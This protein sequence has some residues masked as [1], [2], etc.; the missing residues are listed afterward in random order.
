MCLLKVSALSALPSHVCCSAAGGRLRI[1][2]IGCQL[3]CDS[4]DRWRWWLVAD[5]R[6]VPE[7]PSSLANASMHA[8]AG[9]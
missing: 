3:L 1:V 5:G 2:D 4:P 8:T 7:D 6:M 9:Q